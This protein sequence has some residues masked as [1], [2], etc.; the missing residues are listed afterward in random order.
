MAMKKKFLGLAMAA[1]VAMPAT[2]VYA[3]Q[4]TIE[5]TN[6]D[7]KTIEAVDPA[8]NSIG[9][10]VDV[11]GQVLNSENK[12]G[13]I[14]VEIPT[15][16]AFTVKANSTIDGP[17]YN[18]RNLGS[19]SINISVSAFERVAGSDINIKTKE[20]IENDESTQELTRNNVSLIL[21]GD[22]NGNKTK[23]D[24]GKI[25]QGTPNATNALGTIAAGK[26][27]KITLTGTAGKKADEDGIDKNGTNGSFKLSFKIT[28]T[29]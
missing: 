5:T 4:D 26:T 16:M 27:Q 20:E 18:V 15:A 22:I 14:Q 1:M 2:G 28:K 3:A 10:T 8:N 11:N 6:G 24:L 29:P 25:A 9:T 19:D 21:N 23:V 7:T 13:K 17:E 12:S